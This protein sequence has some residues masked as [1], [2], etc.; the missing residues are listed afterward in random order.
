L[1]DFYYGLSPPIAE[2]MTENPGLKPIVR[3]GLAPAVAMSTIVVNASAAEK[4]AIWGVLLL[5]VALAAWATRRRGRS[6]E[7]I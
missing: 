4:G 3:G 2:F 7:Y 1:V 6:A 5:S